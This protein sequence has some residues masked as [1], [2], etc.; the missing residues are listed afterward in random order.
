MAQ[1]TATSL[2][3]QVHRIF[4]L[5]D[6]MDTDGMAA[7]I[8]DDGQG[9]DEISRG[10][11]RGRD[12][13]EEYFGQLENMV[14]GVS[15]RV[16]DVHVADWGD[17]GVVT[18]VVDQTYTMGGEEQQITAPPRS[19]CAG[20]RATTGRSPSSTASRCPTSRPTDRARSRLRPE[21]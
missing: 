18:C 6:A 11:M 13:L 15:S 7:M 1:E 12:A 20:T 2:E 21:P 14:D 3:Q 17:T 8:A 10:W 9:V 5:V 19:R 16:R 4:E